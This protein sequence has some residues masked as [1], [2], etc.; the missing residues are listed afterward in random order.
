MKSYYIIINNVME[1]I[2]VVSNCISFLVILLF[3]ISVSVYKLNIYHGIFA[4]NG[5]SLL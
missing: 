4:K 2:Y 1:T 3:P 5:V